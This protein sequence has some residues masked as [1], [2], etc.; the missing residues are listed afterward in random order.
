VVER[1]DLHTPQNTLDPPVPATG[2]RE[3]PSVSED[4]L[5][6]DGSK[7]TRILLLAARQPELRADWAGA[8]GSSGSS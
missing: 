6:G 2:E 5:S 4:G 7:R 3:N 1:L 8:N